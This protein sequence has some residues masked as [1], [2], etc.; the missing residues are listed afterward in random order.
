MTQ[1]ATRKAAV[2]WTVAILAACSVPGPALPQTPGLPL[3]VDKWVHVGM[4][5]GFGALWSLA[6]PGRA[7]T[8]LAAGLAYAV[9]IEVWQGALPIGRSPD[10]YDAVADAVGLVAGLALAAWARRRG[11]DPGGGVSG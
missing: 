5:L 8:V 10:P 4:F 9:A 1:S 2:V 3:S 6:A 11:N 7:W